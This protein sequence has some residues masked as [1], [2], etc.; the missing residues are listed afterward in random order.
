MKAIVSL[1]LSMVLLSGCTGAH[2]E[3]FPELENPALMQQKIAPELLHQ[4]IDALVAGVKLRHPDFAGYADEVKLYQQVAALKA[5]ITTPMTRVE[6]FRQIGQLSHLFQDG[7]SFLIWPY[8]ELNALREQGS[9]PFPFLVKLSSNGVFV[10]KQYQYQNQQL[11]AGSQLISING[12]AVTDIFANAQ[13]YVGGETAALRQAFVAERLPFLLWAVYGFID[14][15][16]IEYN[17]LGKTQRLH[18]NNQQ[19]WQVVQAQDTDTTADIAYRRLNDATGYLEV[20]SFDVEPD[21]FS[22]QLKSAFSQIAQDKVSA[23]VIDIRHNTGGNTDTATELASYIANKPFRLV[24]QMTEK[25]NAENR[26]LFG[27]KGFMG[28]IIST[29]WDDYV[30]P[31]TSADH[32][33]GKVVV[34]IGPVSYS[35]AIV[36]ATTVQDNQFGLLAGKATGGFANQ[37]AQGNLFNLPHSQ[38]RAYVAT[39]LLVRPSGNSAVSAV[40]P[41]QPVADKLQDQQNGIDTALQQVLQHLGTAENHAKLQ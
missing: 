13:R 34:L 33:K 38:L 15:F 23:L 27:Y 37:S 36:F 32:F 3:I 12:V 26:G 19:S 29:E 17:H 1:L 25:L 6:F 28:E 5:N 18:I 40:I 22:D 2:L 14:Q 16:D 10:A 11:L 7:H 31:N 39:R 35:A 41:D 30:K 4:D 8:Q 20:T 21:V 9:K 24:S